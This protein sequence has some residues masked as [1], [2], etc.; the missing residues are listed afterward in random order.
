MNSS[1]N[2]FLLILQPMTFS[3]SQ[4]MVFFFGT[5]THIITLS[6]YV[7]NYMITFLFYTFWKRIT[8]SCSKLINVAVPRTID[9]RA[10]NTKRLLNPWERNENHTLCLNSAKAIGCTVVNIG[11][12]DLIEGRV[13]LCAFLF[14]TYKTSNREN[15]LFQWRFCV[16]KSQP[17]IYL[18]NMRPKSLNSGIST[19]L[20]LVKIPR[21]RILTPNISIGMLYTF[22]MC[23]MVFTSKP[24]DYFIFNIHFLYHDNLS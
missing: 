11:T 16:V 19:R 17:L 8:C 4:K 7:T 22:V 2:T 3:K 9:E 5:T 24:F 23:Y 14:F 15:N 20:R 13:C 1:A 6:S 18:Y 10:I 21:K 12:Q